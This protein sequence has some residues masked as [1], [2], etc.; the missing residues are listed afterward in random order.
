MSVFVSKNRI[1]IGRA[2]RV[3]IIY[4]SNSSVLVLVDSRGRMRGQKRR[5]AYKFRGSWP[6]E[7]GN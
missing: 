4:I 6:A 3:L 5:D 7:S 1:M 2:S